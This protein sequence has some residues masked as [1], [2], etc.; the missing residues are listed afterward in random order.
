MSRISDVSDAIKAVLE[1]VENIGGVVDYEFIPNDTKGGDQGVR[2]LFT[3][4]GKI[5]GVQFYCIA[6]VTLSTGAGP[7]PYPKT[8]VWT[9]NFDVYVE[10]EEFGE[11]S[12]R[13]INDLV[14]AIQDA[15]LVDETLGGTITDMIVDDE[16]G[17][18]RVDTDTVNFFGVMCH[19]VTLALQ[20]TLSRGF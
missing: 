9:W 7:D 14:E 6:D 19:Q 4:Y 16:V 8:T 15:L 1:G 12:T 13:D 11:T 17:A 2:D 10:L 18:Q 5:R 3:F 20:T